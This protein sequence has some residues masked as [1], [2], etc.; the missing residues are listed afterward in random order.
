MSDSS[1][2]DK[3]LG[4]LFTSV[5]AGLVTAGFTYKSWQEQTRL[6]IAKARLDEATKSFDRASQFMSARVYHSYHILNGVEDD[7]DATFAAKMDKFEKAVEDWNVAYADL[8]QDFQFSLEIDENGH[9]LPYR[10]IHTKEFDKKLRCNEAFAPGNGPAIVDWSSP[11]W[12]LAALHHCFIAARVKP[13]V[14]SLRAKPT[15]ALTKISDKAA[16][17]PPAEAQEARRKKID[18]LDATVDD[19]KTHSDEVRVAGKRAIAR[20]RNATET[21]SFGRFISSW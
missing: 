17:P 2:T 18:A 7:D 20:L 12:R 6:D 14:L 4:F 9:S 11:T 1:F 5:L 16:A 19:L 21:R 3:F 10:D 15:V 13:I 8:L